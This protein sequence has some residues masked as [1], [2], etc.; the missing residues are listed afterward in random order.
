MF[1]SQ[2]FRALRPLMLRLTVSMVIATPASLNAAPNKT[3]TAL[4]RPI[5]F[6]T[7]PGSP[8]GQTPTW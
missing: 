7:F 2:R 3:S 5:S 1:G 8:L 6:L 4:D